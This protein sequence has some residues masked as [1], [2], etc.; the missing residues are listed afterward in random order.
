[1]FCEIKLLFYFHKDF[2]GDGVVGIADL[3]QTCRQIV[4]D[5]LT[6]DEISTICKKVLDESD[7]DGDGALSYIEFEHVV[8]RASDFLSTFHMRI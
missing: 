7:I 3:E 6:T 4:Q 8:T 1:M 5:G 2:D